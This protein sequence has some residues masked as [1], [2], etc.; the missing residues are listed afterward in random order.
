MRPSKHILR[1]LSNYQLVSK[2]FVDPSCR[3]LVKEVMEERAAAAGLSLIDWV[4]GPST[5]ITDDYKPTRAKLDHIYHECLE[6]RMKLAPMLF[7]T[8][9][10]GLNN[11]QLGLYEL[12]AW[13][14]HWDDRLMDLYH[15]DISE[16]QWGALSKAFSRVRAQT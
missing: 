14:I 7:Y 4:V 11:A 6:N 10:S 12:S 9:V 15:K 13:D 1:E 16:A 5:K 8:R 3:Y 2:F